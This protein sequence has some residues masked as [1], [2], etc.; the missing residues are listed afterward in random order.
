MR[1]IWSKLSKS[2]RYRD[3]FVSVNAKRAF[4]FQLRAIMK[5]RNL[6]QEKLAEMCGLTQGTISRAA[7]PD[8]GALTVTIKTKIANGLDMVYLGTLAPFSDLEKWISNLS[9]DAVQVPTFE[10]E[11]FLSTL[12]EPSAETLPKLGSA[13][14][15]AMDSEHTAILK[16]MYPKY[17][18]AE[19]QGLYLV[20][21]N[22]RAA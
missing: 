15:A 10:E 9:E 7:D 4:A 13:E 18:D 1:R 6:S 19:T 22:M 11:S 16:K 3:E 17:G 12:A 21:V 20:N 8:Y 5:R 14:S 2:K